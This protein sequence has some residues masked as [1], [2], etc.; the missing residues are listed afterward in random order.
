M[1][2]NVI[3]LDSEEKGEDAVTVQAFSNLDDYL[4]L[5]ESDRAATL[6][7]EVVASFK[8]NHE[9]LL[10]IDIPARFWFDS[11]E[12]PR[13]EI[14]ETAEVTGGFRSGY[15]NWVG[16]PGGGAELAFSFFGIDKQQFYRAAYALA[17]DEMRAVKKQVFDLINEWWKED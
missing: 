10:S 13:C 8:N 1:K 12:N 7:I 3:Y 15:G 4:L 5:D 9:Y 6:Y 11:A 2:G 14:D 16:I 17:Y